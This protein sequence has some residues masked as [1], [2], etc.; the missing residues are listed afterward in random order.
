MEA[1]IRAADL[2]V[3]TWPPEQRVLAMISGYFDDTRTEDTIWVVGG[4]VGYP[5]QWELFESLWNAALVRHG[6]PYFHMR[7]MGK[8]NGVFSKW[9]PPEEHQEEVLAFLKDLV[10]AIKKSHLRQFGS[11]V[12]IAELERFNKEKNQKIRAYPLAALACMTQIAHHYKSVAV[13]TIFD[14]VEQVDSKL[15]T[16]REYVESDRFLFPG[17]CKFITSVPLAEGLSYKNVPA[18]QAADFAIWEARRGYLTI[19]PWQFLPDRPG[20]DRDEQWE[21]FK[22]WS[23]QTYD[24]EFPIQRKSLEALIGDNA[25]IKWVLW[26]YQQLSNTH[27]ARRGIW[28]FPADQEQ[29]S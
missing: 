26:D 11:A 27:E 19:K 7:E 6:V 20:G 10:A 22:E 25:P 18:I 21:H 2:C 3:R 1:S 28:A 17:L 8:P 5:N 23:R 16:A 13:T 29:L 14:R 9:H 4:Y 15:K 24:R 12:W